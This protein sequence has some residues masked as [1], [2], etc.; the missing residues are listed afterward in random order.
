MSTTSL[1]K[2]Y[3]NLHLPPR[4]SLSVEKRCHG[5]I[6]K[7]SQVIEKNVHTFDGKNAADF[8]EWYEKIR[9]SLNIYDKAAFQVL[10]G[11]PV[12]SAATHTDGSKLMA[13]NTANED[14]YNVLFFTTKGAAGSVVRR[15]VSKTLDE[16]SGYGQRA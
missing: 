7:N 6:S 1:Y 12:P 14:L 5:A 4:S 11:E 15:F 8:I 16:G 10:Q 2:E 13:W 3:S 9:I